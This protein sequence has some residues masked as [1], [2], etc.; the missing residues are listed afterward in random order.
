MG[1]RITLERVRGMGC[2][3]VD[4]IHLPQGAVAGCLNTVTDHWVP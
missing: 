4:W 1:G 3:D 2:A